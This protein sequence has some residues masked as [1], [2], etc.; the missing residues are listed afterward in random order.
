LSKALAAQGKTAD[1]Q[2]TRRD[3]AVSWAAADSQLRTQ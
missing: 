3:L 2:R 1:A